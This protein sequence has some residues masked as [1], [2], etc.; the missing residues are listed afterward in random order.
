MSQTAIRPPAG[1]GGRVD[2]LDQSAIDDSSIRKE[3]QER[4][5]WG[6]HS[7][8]DL[9]GCNHAT[10]TNAGEVKRFV[11]ELCNAIKMRRYGECI[12][13]DFGDDPKVTGF[14][15]FQLIETSNISAHFANQT[16]RVFLDV[17]SCCYYNPRV[18]AEFAKKF[19]EAKDYNLHYTLR[20]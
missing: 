13:V 20:K 2:D 16:N 7:A 17:F 8:I 6:L 11:Y 12:V 10:I 3:Y 5:A 19:F 14:S 9:H 1:G 4:N 18:V 15:M